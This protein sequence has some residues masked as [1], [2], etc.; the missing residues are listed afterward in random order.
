[1]QRKVRIRTKIFFI[2]LVAVLPTVVFSVYSA[3]SF[4]QT[5][6]EEQE[7]FL[8]NLCDG[9]VNEQRLIVRTAEHM[10]LAISQTRSVQNRDYSFLNKYLR[11]LMVLYPDYAVLLCV[12]GN[13]IVVASG[14]GRTGYS[15]DDRPYLAHARH[16][17]MFT[18]G[19][20]IISRSTGVPAI[21]FTLPARDRSGEWVYLV[22]TYSLEKYTRELSVGRLGKDIILEISDDN[23][24]CIFSSAK[25]PEVKIGDAMP[26]EMSRWMETSTLTGPRILEFGGQG[27]LAS[28]SRYSR[29][30]NSVRVSVRVPYKAVYAAALV[31]VVRIFLLMGGACLSAFLVS[32][33]LA[34]RLFVVRIERLT[35]YTE[36]LARGDMSVRSGINT[37]HDEITVLMEAF[38]SMAA[39]LEERSLSNQR[40][41]REREALL[42][43]LQKRVSDNLQLLS[44][45]IN[46]QIGHSAD[47]DVRLSLMTTHSRVMALALVYETIYLYSDIQQVQMHR[48]CR[49]LADYLVNLYAD[50]GT[51]IACSIGGTDIALPLDKALPLALVL[52]ELV[53]NSILHAFAGKSSGKITISFEQETPVQALMII[54]DDGSGI[55]GDVLRRD[56]LGYEMIEALVEQVRGSLAVESD[57]EG[58]R[59]SVRF[60]VAKTSDTGQLPAH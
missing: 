33:W 53:S 56:T 5:V 10:L 48:Y 47:E 60:S 31:P 45:M 28:A 3:I 38:N 6:L 58:T 39:S 1:M 7:T 15:L 14:I 34:R 36:A 54:Q 24:T 40:T 44:S 59:I 18:M 51:F 46:L 13:G 29:N 43:E 16:T 2:V 9:Y 35:D 21:T 12:N 50:V 20:Y 32:L 41:L 23:G 30:G 52:N 4:Q 49:G 37:A 25:D 17:K 19:Q 11:D 8:A 27:W 26:E 42:Q 57:A 22:A 55:E